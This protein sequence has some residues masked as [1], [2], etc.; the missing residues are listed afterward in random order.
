MFNTASTAQTFQLGGASTGAS[1]YSMFHGATANATTKTINLGTAGVSGSTTNVNIG[2]AVSGASGTTA[3]N[4]GVINLGTVQ[5]AAT[6]LNIGP[7]ITGNTVKF[8]STTG[9]TVNITTDVT[10]GA[11][12]MFAGLSTG[13]VNLGV[14]S[15]ATN[16]NLA[17]PAG[18]V[19]V[20]TT[21][22]NSTVTINGNGT[23]GTATL[24]TNVTTGIV[25]EWTGITTGTVNFATGGASTL[26]FGGNAA[27]VNLGAA[28]GNTVLNI[29]G[30]GTGGTATINTNVTTGAVS[31]MSALTTG[32]MTIGSA[33]AGR[34]AI[35][36]NQASTSTTTGAVTIAG[37]LGVNGAVNA[38]TKSFII[39][40]PT[41]KGKL[42]KHG[43]L[44]G[45]EFGVYTRGK[46]TN[47]RIIELPEYWTGLVDADTITVDLTPIGKFQ[48]LYVEKIEGN[49]VYIDNDAMF[50]G[51]VTC[52]Y[53]VWGERKDVGKL[54][55]EADE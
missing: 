48:K 50:G 33:S 3:V 38:L 2:S 51:N 16:I 14:G 28:A 21:G 5:S 17:G 11:I 46:L 45:P 22:G 26:N 53:T 15:G 52:F 12:T 19:N 9:G 31:F 7:A 18:N 42:L 25:N 10:T 54:D 34:L 8:A 23:S 40:H 29:R 24:S 27:T 43:S 36:F 32:T 44:E 1:T 30:N 35:A 6:T 49:K 37:G 55:I 4:S 47:S 13:T 41:K 39:P 20:G